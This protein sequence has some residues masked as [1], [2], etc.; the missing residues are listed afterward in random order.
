LKSG[1]GEGWRRSVGPN[2]W[3]MKKCYKTVKEDRNI[4]KEKKRKR[5]E[6]KKVKANW[7]G[8]ILCRNCLVKHVIEG[9]TQGRM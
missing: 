3:E 4:P 7:S 5:K 1:A 8:H 2:M 9:K 6:K